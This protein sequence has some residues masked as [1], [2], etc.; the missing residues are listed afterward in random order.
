[1]QRLHSYVSEGFQ[2]ESVIIDN[3]MPL[4]LPLTLLAASS[5]GHA[6]LLKLQWRGLSSTDRKSVV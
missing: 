2:L 6:H 5:N 1:M 4:Q 3:P